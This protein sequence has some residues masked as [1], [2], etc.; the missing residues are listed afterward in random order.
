V[1]RLQSKAHNSSPCLMAFYKFIPGDGGDGGPG[2][3]ALDPLDL[4][5]LFVPFGS[6]HMVPRVLGE[7]G[8]VFITDVFSPE[9]A[10]AL[11]VGLIGNI[12]ALSDGADPHDLSTWTTERLL[13]QLKPGTFQYGNFDAAWDT[14]SDP[15]VRC[16]FAAAHGLVASRKQR[17]GEAFDAGSVLDAYD[18]SDLVGS[19]EM[20][21]VTAPIPPYHDPEAADWAHLDNP[22]QFA[23]CLQGHVALSKSSGCFVVSPRSHLVC[24]QLQ[25]LGR[26]IN[27]NPEARAEAKRLVEEVARGR[28]Q[29]PCVV[30]PGTLVMFLS[31]TLHSNKTVDDPGQA[32]HV[33]DPLSV[34]QWGA[35]VFPDGWRCVVYVAFRRLSAMGIVQRREHVAGLWEAFT[36]NR[37]TKHSG[38]LFPL[39]PLGMYP[40]APVCSEQVRRLFE[41]IF[42]GD[43]I[44][45]RVASCPH[46]RAV[47][48][49]KH[50]DEDEDV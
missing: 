24:E 42:A 1:G 47:L 50:K 8:V 28:F 12:A 34:L 33:L 25:A 39:K 20:V 49:D 10:R 46:V 38:K 27:G 37:I 13:P 5:S 31:R 30:P 17:R 21:N 32:P 44:T 23:T 35:P 43:C 15:R 18:C 6:L 4:K 26:Q 7:N 19:L 48:G 3:D 41:R 9:E 40:S 22:K 29:V 45:R 14:R 16:A 36:N 11:A 2:P